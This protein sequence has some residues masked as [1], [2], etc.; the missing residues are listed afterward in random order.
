MTADPANETDDN[1]HVT[2][3]KLATFMAEEL[4]AFTER[5]GGPLSLEPLGKLNEEADATTKVLI[6]GPSGQAEAVIVCSRPVAP[7]LVRR[8]VENAEAIR[9]LVGRDLGEAI[10]AP[11]Q[12]GYAGGRSYVIFPWC[13]EFSPWKMVRVLQRFYLTKPLLHWLRAATAAAATAHGRPEKTSEAFA[14]K[15]EHLAAQAFL[16]GEIK[17][18]IDRSLKRLQVGH[19]QPCHTFDHNDLWLG[20]VMLPAGSIYSSGRRY[21]YVLIDWGG[22]NRD[23]YGIYDLIRLAMALNLSNTALH[24]ELVAHSEALQC[25]REDTQGHLLAAFGRLHQ[26]L[27]CFPEERFIETLRNCWTTFRRAFRAG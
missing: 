19:W 1:Q 23:G 21:P 24:R 11:L 22:A 4:A 9:A 13:R 7:D 5:V 14:N 8:G 18:A 27:E 2:V 26:H 25:D 15:L 10:I 20:N 12:S 17:S 3:D 16:D 6:R